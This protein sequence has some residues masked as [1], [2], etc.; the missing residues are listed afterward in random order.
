PAQA[1][2]RPVTVAGP[3]SPRAIEVRPGPWRAIFPTIWLAVF[4]IQLTRIFWSYRYIRS[5]KR[6]AVPAASALQQRFESW[7]TS[8]DVRRPARLLISSDIASPMAAGF[9]HPA[10]LLPDAMFEQFREQEL[11]HVLL[12]EI[13]HLARRDDWTN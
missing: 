1:N 9:R 12:H 13:A 3:R 10:V 11:D 8:C 7:L 6:R 4:L 2:P 5:L